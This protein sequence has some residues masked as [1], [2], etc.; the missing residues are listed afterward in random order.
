MV[1]LVYAVTRFGED[2]FTDPIAY[3]LGAAAAVLL[4]VFVLTQR[5]SPDPL[6]PLSLFADRNRADAHLSRCR[7]S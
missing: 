2:G 6:V 7:G 4:V 3:A 5:T 1:S